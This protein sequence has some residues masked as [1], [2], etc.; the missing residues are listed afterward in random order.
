MPECRLRQRTR[1]TAS[2]ATSAAPAKPASGR[3]ASPRQSSP[4][5]RAVFGRPLVAHEPHARA[6]APACARTQNDA[7]DMGA[8]IGRLLVVDNAETPPTATRRFCSETN[9]RAGMP[10]GHALAPPGDAT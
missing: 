1:G 6:A 10:A 2:R 8:H 3:T 7:V 5:K 4:M 9:S